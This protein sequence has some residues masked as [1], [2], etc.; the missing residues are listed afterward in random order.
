[1]SPFPRPGYEKLTRYLP[2]RSPVELDLS[3]NTNMW[4][5]HPDALAVLRNAEPDDVRRYP[6]LYADDLREA[7]AERAGVTPE[8]ITTGCGSDDVLDSI[9]KASGGAEGDLVSLAAPTFSMTQPLAR[10]NGVPSRAVMWEDALHDLDR[11][12][13]GDPSVIYICRPNNPTGHMVPEEWVQ[14][15]I[16]RC[17]GGPLIIV[18]EAYIDYGGTSFA[19]QAAENPGLVVTRT[20]SK[21]FGLAGLRVGWGVGTPETVEAIDKARGPYKV[22]LLSAKAAAVALRDEAGWVDNMVAECTRNRRRA[23]AELDR[24]GLA[25][26]PSHTNF[27]FFRAPTGDAVEDARVLRGMGV[28]LRPFPQTY[29]GGWDGMRCSVGPWSM[30]ETMLTTLDEYGATVEFTEASQRNVED[31]GPTS[32]GLPTRSASG[33]GPGGGGPGDGGGGAASS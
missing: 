5:P 8:N 22:A 21:A 30:M 11:L 32:A 7:A 28:G 24:R 27:M 15:I 33:G 3:D 1:M 10:M 4:G 16:D 12:L 23:E 20:L 19:L 14:A 25:P 6:D 2:D 29:P 31:I 26:L 17:Q 13:E 18:D 9:F